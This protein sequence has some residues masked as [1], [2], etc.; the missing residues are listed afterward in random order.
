[1]TSS[2]S[3]TKEN[4]QPCLENQGHADTKKHSNFNTSLGRRQDKNS[5]QY[6]E[7]QEYVGYLV[8]RHRP[9]EK[10]RD[11]KWL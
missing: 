11:K 8:G 4:R 9:R 7:D 6:K 5:A 10:R 2:F 3:E 1:M